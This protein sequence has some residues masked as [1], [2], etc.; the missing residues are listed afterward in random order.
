MFFEEYDEMEYG[1]EVNI[2][3]IRAGGQLTSINFY[4]DEDGCFLYGVTFCQK[5]AD[6]RVEK[7]KISKELFSL[8]EKEFKNEDD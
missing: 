6:S 1:E 5:N 4:E 3:S 2:L 7:I 8:L